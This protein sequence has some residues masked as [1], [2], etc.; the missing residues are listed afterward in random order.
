MAL[1]IRSAGGLCLFAGILMLGQYGEV[2]MRLTGTAM[3]GMM[4]ARQLPRNRKTTSATRTKA[5]SRALITS[6]GRNLSR[7]AFTSAAT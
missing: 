4:V 2:P 3:T 7:M 5:S 6:R 1:I